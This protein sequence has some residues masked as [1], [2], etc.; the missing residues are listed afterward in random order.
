[1]LKGDLSSYVMTEN[2]R[3]QVVNKLKA[4]LS[5]VTAVKDQG[6]AKSRR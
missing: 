5:F 6:N 4:G 3:I 1:M 2:L